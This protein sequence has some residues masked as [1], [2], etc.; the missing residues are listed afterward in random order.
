[1]TELGKETYKLAG[2]GQ[3]R[4]VGWRDNSKERFSCGIRALHSVQL[5]RVKLMFLLGLPSGNDATAHTAPIQ[6]GCGYPAS[7]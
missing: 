3:G 5:E 6:R 4:M 7:A 1:M 2:N